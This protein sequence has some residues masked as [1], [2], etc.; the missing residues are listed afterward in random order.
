MLHYLL[1]IWVKLQKDTWLCFFDFWLWYIKQHD[2]NLTFFN[3]SS[4]IS[5]NILRTA[6]TFNLYWTLGRSN[7]CSINDCDFVPVRLKRTL[8]YYLC[9]SIKSLV[10]PG[11]SL[12]IET[13]FSTS[14]LINVLF[15]AFGLPAIEIFIPSLAFCNLYED[16]STFSSCLI[17]AEAFSF[18][19]LI[20][21]IPTL[22]YFNLL[23]IIQIR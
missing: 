12:T 17:K 20:K 2:A 8:H 11:I 18:P 21:P 7:A 15:P 13:Y 1:F 9:T 22:I 3:A 19:E 23:K 10:V 16:F 6:D 5:I 14:R 4:S